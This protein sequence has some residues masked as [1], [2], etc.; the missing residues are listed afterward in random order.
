MSYQQFSKDLKNDMFRNGIFLYGSED[1]LIRW[2]LQQIIGRYTEE[3]FREHNLIDV[4]G[5][6]ANLDDLIGRARTPS[7]FPGRRILVIR[8]LPMLYRKT[9]DAVLKGEGE[10]LLAFLS[11]KS[12]DS[13]L[14]LTLDAEHK[15]ELTAYGKKVAKAA[16]SYAFDRLDR[17]AL[18]GFISKRVRAA[19]KYIGGERWST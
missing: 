8:N 4:S 5:E 12:E 16:S 15:G 7:M 19:G 17:A 6:N 13:F 1:F 14:V 3:G 10:R 2:A 11:G 18:R 9:V